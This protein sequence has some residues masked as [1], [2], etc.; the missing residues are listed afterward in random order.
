M[1]DSVGQRGWRALPNQPGEWRMRHAAL[2][3]EH[4][5]PRNDISN[6]DGIL[7]GDRFCAA[8]QIG[9]WRALPNQPGE[10]RM[11]HA[12]LPAEHE[13]PRNDIS[14]L[15]GILPGDRFCAAI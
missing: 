13:H 10:W 3:A 14:N 15:D 7:P 12:A 4:E 2:P 5:H 1:L 6:L 9:R 8:I 11:R